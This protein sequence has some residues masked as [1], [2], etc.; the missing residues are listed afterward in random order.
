[1]GKGRGGEGR[2]GGGGGEGRGGE[3]RGGRAHNSNYGHY[4]VCGLGS[5]HLDQHFLLV[6]W[7]DHLPYMR[8]LLL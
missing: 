8:A 7:L 6:H 2:T 1:M 4:Y 5:L 3:G